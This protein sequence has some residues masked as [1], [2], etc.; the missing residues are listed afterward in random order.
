MKVLV[1]GGSGHVGAEVVRHLVEHGHEVVS[2]DQRRPDPGSHPA[3]VRWILVDLNDVGE[4]A[5][6]MAGC[7]AV[8]HLG[9]IPNPYWKPDEV[10]F[11]NNVG[12]TFA[13]FQAASL[14]GVRK[15][16]YAS[17]ISALGPSWAPVGFP[18]SFVPADESHPLLVKDPYGLSKEV[19][20]R[21]AEMFH[22]RDGI[23]AIGIRFHWVATMDQVKAR[24]IEVAADPVGQ[25]N[26]RILWGYVDLRD[27][28]SICRLA[29]E[30]DG[31]G[32]DVFNAVAADTLSDIPTEELVR[33]YSPGTE[34]RKPIAGTA[35]AYDIS[36][37]RDVLGWVPQHSWRTE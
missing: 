10:V 26:Y 11:M 29:I 3:G 22:R 18:V 5:G 24:A 17:S 2:I 6:A 35:S 25:E 19:D 36:H 28:A 37:A 15:I 30:A 4:V 16:A 27:A 1:T 33:T 34:I 31:L 12:A 7:D 14:L 21:I 32:Y 8:V 13:V 23:Q 9:A 20:E